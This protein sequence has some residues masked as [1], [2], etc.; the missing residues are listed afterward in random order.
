[1]VN[2]GYFTVAEHAA[3]TDEIPPRCSD[4]PTVA[5][6]G[7]IANRPATGRL[8][9]QFGNASGNV[10]PNSGNYRIDAPP[11][12]ADLVV[13]HT[14]AAVGTTA[15]TIVDQVAISRGLAASA[16]VTKSLDFA[17]ATAV[18][19]FPATIATTGQQRG[20]ATTTLFASGGTSVALVRD[21]AAPFEVEAL[22][23][24]QATTAD[25]YET[26][27][28]LAAQGQSTT[29]TIV[30]GAPADQTFT[31][32]PGLGGAIT[33]IAA[34]LISTTW[35]AYANAVG[36]RWEASQTLTATQCGTAA[37][38]IAWTALISN[39]YA[40]GAPMFAMPD[41]AQ[42]AGFSGDFAFVTGTAVT[43]DTQGI[44]S[45]AG[46]ADFPTLAPAPAGTQRTNARSDWSVT[47]M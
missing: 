8:V 33:T 4:A 28:S 47:P 1:V 10:E 20:V 19:T 17:T 38:A 25:V 42:L 15:D 13:V 16:P 9:A 5:I 36:Y 32:P 11:G 35:A 39:G 7:T 22:A 37:C 21:T 18:Q 40:G 46:V 23:V 45:S 29:T 2:L 24:A 31:A 43:G 6:T 41:L 34:G 14:G 26:T 44:T 3:I 12:T 30:T 27:L